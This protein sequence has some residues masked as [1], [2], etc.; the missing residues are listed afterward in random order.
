MWD[1]PVQQALRAL[2]GLKV[3]KEMSAQQV[4]LAL[5]AQLDL[6]VHKERKELQ[7]QQDLKVIQEQRVRLDQLVHKVQ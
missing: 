2:Q 5:Q 4:P 1:L 6:P 3:H 7:V